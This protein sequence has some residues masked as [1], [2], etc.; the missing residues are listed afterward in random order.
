[1][2][3]ENGIQ[4][5]D[6]YNVDE[7]GFAMGL[8]ATAKVVTRAEYYGWRAVLQPGNR[9]WVTIIE[10]ISADGH[11]LPPTVVFKGEKYIASWFDNLPNNWRF[12]VSESGWTTD[13]IV[14]RW[15]QDQFIPETSSS[16]KGK[17]PNLILDGHGSHLTPQFD[18]I[19][20]ENAIILLCMPAHSSHHLQPLDIGCFEMLK[21]SYG[22]MVENQARIGHDHITKQDFLNAYPTVHTETYKSETIQNSFAAAGLAP[23]DPER[24][25]SKL[26]ISLRNP[27]PGV[28]DQAVNQG[29]FRQ[30][31]RNCW[32]A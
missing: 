1:M 2:V 31:H 8:I 16:T 26:N 32:S 4:P 23:F 3:D 5:G 24:V 12:K 21:R 30:K 28:A 25:P 11:A 29:F 18:K 15:L 22:R 9:E 19:C 20:S 6:V 17:Y 14:L 27:S 10:S 13:E 7:T